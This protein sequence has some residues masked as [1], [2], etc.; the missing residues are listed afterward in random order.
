MSRMRI[1][2]DRNRG[3]RNG[4]TGGPY[5]QLRG[6]GVDEG[7]TPCRARLRA[8]ALT[9]DFPSRS[10]PISHLTRLSVSTAPSV[11]GRGR[12]FTV[13]EAL[14]PKVSI[15]ASHTQPRVERRHLV[16]GRADPSARDARVS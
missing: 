7:I 15:V 14:N 12:P 9:S 5:R 3:F 2:A 16:H 6:G 8:A 1:P 4:V 13:R 11:A 10:I